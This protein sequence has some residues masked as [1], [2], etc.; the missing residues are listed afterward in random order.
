M[1]SDFLEAHPSYPFFYLNEDEWQNAVHKYP[2]LLNN[3]GLNY[4]ERTCTASIIPGQEGY[5]NNEKV[6]NQ[7]ERL[8][9]MLEFKEVYHKPIQHEFEVVVD[10]ARTHTALIFNINDFRFVFIKKNI[11]LL[12]KLSNKNMFFLITV[13]LTLVFFLI[14][15]FP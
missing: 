15:Q 4:A 11:F 5:L 14:K 7:F 9:Q 10:N 6:L 12:F 8:F 3:N 13:F 2:S 1:V